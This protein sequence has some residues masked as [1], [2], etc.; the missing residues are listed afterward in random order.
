M[1]P[2]ILHDLSSAS[3]SSSGNST[4]YLSSGSSDTHPHSSL[5][6]SSSDETDADPTLGKK[7]VQVQ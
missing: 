5:P 7:V 2:S 4:A 6:S 3:E 1:T